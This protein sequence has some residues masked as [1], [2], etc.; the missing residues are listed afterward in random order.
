MNVCNVPSAD[1]NASTRRTLF[2][3]KKLCQRRLSGTALPNNRNKLPGLYME[4]NTLQ[5]ADIRMVFL[6]DAVE[7]YHVLSF[8]ELSYALVA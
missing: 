8:F 1:S 2:G 3:N 4:I 5:G 6:V 7:F